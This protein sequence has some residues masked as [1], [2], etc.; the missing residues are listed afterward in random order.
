[1]LHV[2]LPERPHELLE[3]RQIEHARLVDV[4]AERGQ[5]LRVGAVQHRQRAIRDVQVGQ[6][7][8]E[9]VAHQEAHQH[10]VVD[11]LLHVELERE[12][13][14]QPVELHLEVLPH[15]GQ[16]QEEEGDFLGCALAFRG[17][18]AEFHLEKVRFEWM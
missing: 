3:P 18:L 10:P 16:V 6:V 12:G 9:V 13:V 15:Q 4:P 11:D 14:P 8:Y 7:R 2:Y 5:H 17:L 1:M